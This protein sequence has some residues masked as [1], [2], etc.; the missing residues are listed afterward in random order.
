VTASIGGPDGDF[1]AV[2]DT[3]TNMVTRTISVAPG[4][5]G[6]AITPNGSC[7]YVTISSGGN[8]VDLASVID[9]VTNTVIA[10][11]NRRVCA[12]GNRHHLEWGLSICF[13]SSWQQCFRTDRRPTPW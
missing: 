7:I 10:H 4:P 8:G 12:N 5:N 9:T 2:I 13:E 6:V 1:V 3:A 11:Y